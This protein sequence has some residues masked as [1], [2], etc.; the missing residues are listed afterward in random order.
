MH[1]LELYKYNVI[2]WKKKSLEYQ[3]AGQHLKLFEIFNQ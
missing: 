2:N 3:N 1:K